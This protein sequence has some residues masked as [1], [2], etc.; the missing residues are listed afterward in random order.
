MTA[1]TPGIHTRIEA[2]LLRM[3]VSECPHINRSART[4]YCYDCDSYIT[5]KEKP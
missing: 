5:E 3:E 1:E 2:F 4:T